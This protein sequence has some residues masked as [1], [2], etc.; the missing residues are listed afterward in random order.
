M[1]AFI[2]MDMDAGERV[3]RFGQELGETDAALKVVD[4]GIMHVT[5][6]FLGDIDGSLVPEI[7]GCMERSVTQVPQFRARLEGVGAFPKMS[8]MKVIWI[9]VEEGGNMTV[10]AQR[11]EEELSSLG[12]REE[13]R[14]FH[15]HLTVARVKGSR[16]MGKVKEVMSRWDGVEFGEQTM[17]SIRLKR[18]ELGPRGPTYYTVEEVPLPGE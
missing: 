11:L 5:L 3:G 18:S 14:P 16:G 17:D 7:R 4:P 9:G 15:P 13:R 1:R 2:S 8:K 10:L 12:F 6:K